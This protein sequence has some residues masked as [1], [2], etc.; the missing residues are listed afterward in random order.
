MRVECRFVRWRVQAGRLGRAA[1]LVVGLGASAR[2][3]LVLDG[4]LGPAGPV[5]L[6]VDPKGSFAFVV[7]EDLGQRRDTNL[8]HSFETFTLG[9]GQFATFTALLPTEHVFARVTGGAPSEI[10]GTLRSMIPGASL[11]LLNPSGVFFAPNTN[12]QSNLDVQG[13]FHASTADALRFEGGAAFP[14]GVPIAEGLSFAS[15]T[16]FGFVA[17]APAAIRVTGAKL[18]VPAGESLSLVGGALEISGSG[19][20]TLAASGGEIGLAAVGGPAVLPARVSALDAFADGAPALGVV[21]LSAGAIITADS[22]GLTPDANGTIAIRAGEFVINGSRLDAN[23]RS[24]GPGAARAIDLEAQRRATITGS[25]TLLQ[26]AALAVGPGGG[27][28]IAA[29]EVVI[30]AGARVATASFGA[31]PAGAVEVDAESVRVEGHGQLFSQAGGDGPAGA[32][33]IGAGSVMIEGAGQIATLTSAS[34]RGGD[35]DIAARSVSV[36]AGTTNTPS[37]VTTRTTSVVDGAGRGGDL[38]ISTATLDVREG[39]EVSAI[40]SGAGDA[41]SLEVDASDSILV[42]GGPIGETGIFARTLRNPAATDP[43]DRRRGGD[44]G[45]LVL[46][47]GTLDVEAG[48]TISARTFGPGRAGNVELVADE[49]VRVDGS[50]GATES[51]VSVRGDLGDGGTLTVRSDRLELSNGGALLS[52]ASS[53]GDGG[54]VDVRAGEVEIAGVDPQSGFPAGIFAESTPTVEDPDLGIF[55]GDAGDIV[56]EGARG[57]VLENGARISARTRGPGAGGDV[58][59]TGGAIT[60]AGGASV[61]A[62]SEGSGN[63]GSL[64]LRSGSTIELFAG[65]TLSTRAELADGGNIFLVAPKLVRV[66][67]SAI[68]AEVR[69]GVGTGGNV[70]IDPDVVV[71]RNGRVT[72]DAFGGTGGNIRITTSGLFANLGGVATSRGIT[73]SSAFGVQG[74][75]EL[76][77]PETDLAGALV[78][79]EQSFLDREALL[80]SP[81]EARAARTGSFAVR[82]AGP[83]PPPPG[84]PLGSE[85]ASPALRVPG[86]AAE[87]PSREPVPEVEGVLRALERCPAEARAEP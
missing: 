61:S 64:T 85:Y 50:E 76:Q 14:T 33:R 28:R 48:G 70:E 49:R 38:R 57:V 86:L 21:T 25:T 15:P 26:A 78:S 36:K 11:W 6:A 45:N 84:A 54:T 55:A 46:R 67:D 59:I 20:L 44:G 62:Q 5:P 81:C 12:N 74:T 9:R 7:S 18:S 52:T 83:I 22:Q 2:A 58:S 39:G 1:I 43:P 80:R 51:L 8:F 53:A 68:T 29:D 72:A 65:S 32:V 4:S 37:R 27:L 16:E 34:G 79:L 71:L 40:T 10:A 19:G 60:L 56:V 42:R 66:D 63:A 30:S 77:A 23:N 75:V 3:D 87:P 82:G 47:T 17:D 35:V 24:P 69:S 31:G 73:A 13:A 41:G